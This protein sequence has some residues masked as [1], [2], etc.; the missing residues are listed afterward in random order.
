MNQALMFAQQQLR[1]YE[2]R[3]RSA[4]M[5]VANCR[6]IPEV[7]RAARIHEPPMLRGLTRGISAPKALHQAAVTRINELVDA[8]LKTLEA[9][10]DLALRR[11]AVGKL[12]RSDWDFLRGTY[13]SEW[14]RA[15]DA[16][17]RLLL[18]P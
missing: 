8:Q 9:E 13:A 4:A 14:R 10:P 5:T 11:A 6:S 12:H 16:S 15:E 17:Q 3:C 7:V 18:R 1:Q 2:S